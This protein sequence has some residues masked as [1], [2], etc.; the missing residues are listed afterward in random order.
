MGLL[1]A[2]RVRHKGI[3][4]PAALKSCYVS[5][6]A[7]YRRS[8]PRFSAIWGAISPTGA[9]QEYL[10]TTQDEGV[11]GARAAFLREALRSFS[12]VSN[13]D[14]EVTLSHNHYN[15]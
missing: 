13:K 15:S 7:P 4:P 5:V 8:A 6:R 3:H 14:G 2:G 11:L 1:G 10:A 9:G 12:C